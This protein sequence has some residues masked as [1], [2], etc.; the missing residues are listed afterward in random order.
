MVLPVGSLPKV[1]PAPCPAALEDTTLPAAASRV[2]VQKLMTQG[3]PEAWPVH[4]Q[5]PLES[6]QHPQPSH[7]LDRRPDMTHCVAQ[8]ISGPGKWPWD[9]E[10]VTKQKAAGAALSQLPLQD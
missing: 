2:S 1:G 10:T 9:S 8:Q 4:D 3:Q 7:G 5:C 6:G